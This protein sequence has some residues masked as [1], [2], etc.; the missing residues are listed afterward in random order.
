MPVTGPVLLAIALASHAPAATVAAAPAATWNA[1]EFG[2]S[3]PPYKMNHDGI[4]VT[5]NVPPPSEEESKAMTVVRAPGFAPFTIEERVAGGQ[6][7]RHVGIGK[8]AARD[9][10]PSVLLQMYTGGAHCCAAVT[11]IVPIEGKFHAVELPFMDG[12][13]LDAFPPDVDGDGV[14]DFLR[15]DERFLYAFSSYARSNPPPQV[16][17]V[18]GGKVVDVS[19]RPA[20]A[21]L[22]E[23]A[24]AESRAVCAD[25][26]ERDRNGACASYV[27]AAAR[28][29]RYDQ[30]IN[31]VGAL[32]DNS[33]GI[34]RPTQCKV[35]LVDYECPPGKENRFATFT[36]ALRFFLQKNGYAAGVSL[37]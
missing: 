1:V 23:E 30:A 15:F 12:E 7:P 10:I 13:G 29:G 16:L 34:E 9:P 3:K 37:P 11:A 2:R 5:I 36:E 14:V 33:P 8:L 26:A 27:A 4:E 18:V 21:G 22:F 6:Y 32:A 20:F 24:A 28:L 31:E 35:E 25:Q 17:N 19:S